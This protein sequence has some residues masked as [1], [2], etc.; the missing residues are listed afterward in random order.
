MGESGGGAYTV[1]TLTLWTSCI[2]STALLCLSNMKIPKITPDP[3]NQNL[4]D[5]EP[6]RPQKI[7]MPINV[8]SPIKP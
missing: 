1:T 8:R 4:L 7:L 2:S 6:K 5:L 3:V